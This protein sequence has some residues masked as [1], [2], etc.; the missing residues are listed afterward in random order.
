M[1]FLIYSWQ[2]QNRDKKKSM[3]YRNVLRFH[4]HFQLKDNEKIDQK[5][6][7]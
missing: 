6:F 4:N 5:K 3:R 1:K 2:K 7:R